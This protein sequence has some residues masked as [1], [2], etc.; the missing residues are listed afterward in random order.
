MT[1]ITII[2][3]GINNLRS[4]E[5]ALQHLG[6]T[7][8]IARTP[9]EVVAADK[10]VLP[11]VAAFGSTMEALN[12]AGITEPLQQRI[13]DG[14]PILGICVGQQLLFDWSEEL[15][16]HAG[17]GIISGKVQRFPDVP[18]L[19]V[20]HIG[21]SALQ[22]PRETRLFKGI[23]PGEMVY[24]VHSF[25]AVPD[26]KGVI[27]ATAQHG[28]EFVASIERENVMAVQFHAEK[29]SRVGMKI[30]DNFAKIKRIDD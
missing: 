21:W 27:A 24:F 2:D 1:P 16:V 22:F 7:V 15:G 23:D 18:G 4:V 3:C 29:S 26:D 13:S 6:H 8:K 28:V 11:G 30:L 20:P 9:E 5:K 14:V 17:L 25:F 10:L 19:K 12:E